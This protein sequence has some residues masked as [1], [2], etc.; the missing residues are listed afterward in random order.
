LYAIY[1]ERAV[2]GRGVGRRLL[3][4]ALH[5]L[6]LGGYGAATLR[7]LDGNARAIRFYEAAGW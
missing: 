1:L 2:L 6:R 3:T 5:D 7:V 4:Y